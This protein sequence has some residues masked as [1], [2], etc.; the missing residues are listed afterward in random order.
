MEAVQRYEGG[1]GSQSQGAESRLRSVVPCP[2][3][4][5]A[6]QCVLLLFTSLALS[7]TPGPCSFPLC[8]PPDRF[9]PCP[10]LVPHNAATHPH[11]QEDRRHAGD[12]KSRPLSRMSWK[13]RKGERGRIQD[14]A[15]VREEKGDEDEG[16]CGFMLDRQSR[17]RMAMTCVR[18][19]QGKIGTRG[20]SR[21]ALI[22]K[23]SSPL[24]DQAL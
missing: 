15:G 7:T 13:D 23:K 11:S 16:G 9:L 8:R 20:G 10:N 18:V 6:S 4:S 1:S 17:T 19:Q 14:F 5:L 21:V 24:Q 22:A 2:T 3:S 12:K